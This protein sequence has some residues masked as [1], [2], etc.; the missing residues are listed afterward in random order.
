MN[1][2][3]GMLEDKNLELVR[4]NQKVIFLYYFKLLDEISCVNQED[5]TIR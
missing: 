2:T 3:Q 4:M 1:E 5:E